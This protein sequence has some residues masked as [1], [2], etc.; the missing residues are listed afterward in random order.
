MRALRG[1]VAATGRLPRSRLFGD[2]QMDNGKPLKRLTVRTFRRGL[3]WA[4]RA[5]RMRFAAHPGAARSD[6]EL[7]GAE[8]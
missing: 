4:D 7:Q 8:V 5:H 3:A 6:V 2:L 1:A